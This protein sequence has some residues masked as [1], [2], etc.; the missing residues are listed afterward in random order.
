M[1]KTVI[2]DIFLKYM[3]NIQKKYLTFTKTCHFYQEKNLEK[4]KKLVFSIEDKEKYVVHIRAFKQVLN[5]RLILKTVH[6]VI[7]FNQKAWSKPN[8]D[9]I[10]KLRKKA[11]IILKKISFS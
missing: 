10:T 3:L 5:H 6:T 8:K 1:M 7:Q 2:K 11:K 9:V 4:I